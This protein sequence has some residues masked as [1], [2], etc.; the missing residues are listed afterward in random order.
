M[1]GDG[2]SKMGKVAVAT[3]VVAVL[4][5]PGCMT[6]PMPDIPASP[7]YET[8]RLEYGTSDELEESQ[9]GQLTARIG[10]TSQLA[11]VTRQTVAGTN[12]ALRDH[13]KLMEEFRDHQP[14]SVGD[15]YYEWEA[16]EGSE[17]VQYRI[18][19]VDDDTHEHW[20][21]IG[22]SRSDSAVVVE[23]TMTPDE[24]DGDR[25][26]G[27]GLITFDFD[28]LA[29]VQDDPEASQ[30]LM[31][32]AFRSHGG[33]RQVAVGLDEVAGLEGD[34][35][36]TGIFDYTQL[37]DERG[38]FSF[39]GHGSFEGGDT[40]FASF[41]AAWT[42][43]QQGRIDARFEGGG[44]WDVLVDQCW[45]ADQQISYMRTEPESGDDGGEVE[46]CAAPLRDVELEATE[47][48]EPDDVIPDIPGEH[49]EEQ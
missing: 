15:D 11:D 1:A 37:A 32:L 48:E 4:V 23:G 43:D 39:F 24:R 9:Q 33:V 47:H 25:Q 31:H 13:L 44:D 38:F 30:G 40:E 42:P 14:T 35:P 8:V 45:D 26:Q 17:Y 28:A 10:E 29:Q 2:W 19:R 41:D 20:L 34:E 12:A 49:P 7:E 36:L 3:V 21:R 46:D 5:W 18:E 27:E 16:P 22:E 6:D